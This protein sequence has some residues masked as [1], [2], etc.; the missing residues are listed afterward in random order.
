[1]VV[2]V[3]QNQSMSAVLG[4]EQHQTRVEEREGVRG[5]GRE[6]GGE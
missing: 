5:R 3:A 4:I 6:A 1:M 2:V